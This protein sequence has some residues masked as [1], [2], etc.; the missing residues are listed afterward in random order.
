MLC[1]LVDVLPYVAA[2]EDLLRTIGIRL[3]LLKRH[4]FI[5]RWLLQLQCTYNGM[6]G[7]QGAMLPAYV[8]NCWWLQVIILSQGL[9]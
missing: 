3:P 1:H 2:E 7:R 4:A 6:Q 5:H 9:G 8:A